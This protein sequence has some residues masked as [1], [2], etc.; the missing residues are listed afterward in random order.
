MNNDDKSKVDE[1][2]ESLYS[3]TRYKGVDDH[4]SVLKEGNVA[5]VNKDWNSGTIDEMLTKE[6]RKTD[7]HSTLKKVFFVALLF[8]I[9]AIGVAGYIF[10][11]GGNYISSKNVDIKV[12]GPV[13]VNA[14]ELLEL[15]VSVV[16]KNNA[17]LE[18][19][20][21]FVQYPEGTRNPEDST[22]PLTRTREVLGEIKAGRDATYNVRSILFGE[23]GET[24]QIKITIEYK[25]KGSNATF[26]KEKLYDIGIG[27]TP[28]SLKIEMPT[29]VTSGD[30][31]TGTLTI[32]ANSSEILKNVIIK[33]EYPYGFSFIDSEPTAREGN[34]TWII[35]DLNP[36][37]KKTI[38]IKGKL[39]GQD[40]EERTFRFY[41]GIATSADINTFETPLSY[42]SE[43]LPIKR[44]GL[45]LEVKINSGNSLAAVA[46][47][48]KTIS[49]TLS[50]VNNLS[51]NLENVRIEARLSGNALDKSSVMPQAGGF[52]D[53]GN[54]MIIWD[55]GGETRLEFLAPGDKGVVSFT[56]AS[57]PQLN[58]FNKNQ[59]I[60]IDTT[61]YGV[62][63]G[64]SNTI[65]VTDNEI[66]KIASEI[67][68]TGKSLYSR[69]PFKNTGPIPPHAEEATTYTIVLNAR[70]TQN[71]ISE[72][73][74][75][76][77]LGSNVSWLGKVSPSTENVSYDELKKTLTWDIGT[78]ASGS[79]FDAVAREVSMQ[80]SLTPSVGQ[81]GNSPIL[82]TNIL[83]SGKD[84]FTNVPVTTFANPI[85]T[86]ISTDPIYV[87]GDELVT[88]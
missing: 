63:Q 77:Q 6:R 72:G 10:L 55:K 53:S 15:G 7:Q 41:A 82:L 67:N 12:L 49:A 58:D 60:N 65:S 19:A 38:T 9:C 13:N 34:N 83:F 48:G 30:T 3:R 87:Q 11:E 21:L 25:V 46:P 50:Y 37:D 14:G 74:V 79:G 54:N 1:L 61:I 88:K 16:N 81:V 76:A 71:D 35:G 45:G 78:L 23:K 18:S 84:G 33:S 40:D 36:G 26:S 80:L 32:L 51:T 70:N 44:P 69:G 56:F 17:D 75:T 28:V 27:D 47:A 57:Q 29:S 5:D 66:V 8:F 20:V 4:R 43:T 52:Y 59:Q 62:P 68:L 64:Y 31:F 2:S 24:K 39:S 42:V 22:M 85:T 73:K 86:K